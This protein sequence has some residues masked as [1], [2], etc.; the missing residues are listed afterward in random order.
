MRTLKQKEQ[1]QPAKI[2]SA[3]YS[4]HSQPFNEV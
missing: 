2:L 4:P 1:T 3:L